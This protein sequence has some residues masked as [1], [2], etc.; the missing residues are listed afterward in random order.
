[1]VVFASGNQYLSDRVGFPANHPDISDDIL[2]V[3]AIDRDGRRSAFSN[4]APQLD[5]VA[6]GRSIL[7]T[8]PNNNTRNESGTSMAAPHVAGVAALILSRNPGLTGQQVRNIIKST[9]NRNLPG[10]TTHENRPNGTWNREVGHGLVN[11][12]AAVNAALPSFSVPPH[13]CGNAATI[14]INNMQPGATINWTV[15]RAGAVVSSGQTTGSS[16]NVR[17]TN[18]GTHTI[19]GTVTHN[20]TTTPLAS[21]TWNNY[22][23]PSSSPRVEQHL[24]VAG[25]HSVV[26][27]CGSDFTVP[28][29]LVHW[30]PGNSYLS[31]ATISW[32]GFG[33]AGNGTSFRPRVTHA[34]LAFPS[35]IGIF[36]TLTHRCGVW[37]ASLPVRVIDGCDI[38]FSYSP[39]PVSDVLTVDIEE[40]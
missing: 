24:A 32:S 19:E 35:Y 39:N 12:Y 26:I 2:V 16:I 1:M 6:P 18:V 7:S 15:R 5:V 13:S 40:R 34:D 36:V 14:S 20:G 37:S 17:L 33:Q 29:F 3:G 9:A 30:G 28:W 23:I 38:G 10:F 4:H 8:A 21:R 27:P 31:G 22:A 11:A 25:Q